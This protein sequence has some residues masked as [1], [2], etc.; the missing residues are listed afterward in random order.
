MERGKEN[1]GERK[2]GE[3][4]SSSVS[5]A[6]LHKDIVNLLDFIERLNNERVQIALDMD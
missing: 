2:D 5:S 3:E 1:E 4:N 6:E